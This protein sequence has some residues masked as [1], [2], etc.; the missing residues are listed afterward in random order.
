ML[1]LAAAEKGAALLLLHFAAV[2]FPLLLER[3][4]LLVEAALVGAHFGLVVLLEQVRRL[5]VDH[6][7]E[8]VARLGAAQARHKL[9]PEHS[10]AA[11]QQLFAVLLEGKRRC[12]GRLERGH[13]FWRDEAHVELVR[14][15]QSTS[16]LKRTWARLLL[17][18]VRV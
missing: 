18:F 10:G 16:N 11:R 7:L 12:V 15:E 4:L 17:D 5:V 2:G 3:A 8:L 14:F 13:L 9:G 6:A 1:A